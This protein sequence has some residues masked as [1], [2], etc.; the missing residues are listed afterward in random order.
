MRVS[1]VGWVGSRQCSPPGPA[2]RRV[3]VLAASLAL[4][5]LPAPGA[6]PAAAQGYPGCR[7]EVAAVRGMAQTISNCSDVPTEAIATLLSRTDAAY[8]GLIRPGDR[9]LANDQWVAW[10][11]TTDAPGILRGL[12]AVDADGRFQGMTE[13]TIA[14]DAAKSVLAIGKGVFS[15]SAPVGYKGLHVE[16]WKTVQ[17]TS[18]V[19]DECA[20]AN[21]FYSVPNGTPYAN[22]PTTLVV[23]GSYSVANYHSVLV[24]GLE[25]ARPSCPTCGT[26]TF[27]G[28]NGVAT[29]LD[30]LVSYVVSRYGFTVETALTASADVNFTGAAGGL[31]LLLN[32]ACQEVPRNAYAND[33]H[34]AACDPAAVADRSIH[35]FQ[36]ASVGAGRAT[37]APGVALSGDVA[38]A[39]PPGSTTIGP[40]EDRV[41]AQ[42]DD[43]SPLSLRYGDG[44]VAMTV[45]PGW[46]VTDPARQPF[47]AGL[48]SHFNATPRALGWDGGRGLTGLTGVGSVD[49]FTEPPQGAAC[50]ASP[51][52]LAV[53]PTRGMLLWRVGLDR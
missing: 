1:K 38:D 52:S 19:G 31:L 39:F 22:D 27:V 29:E 5:V 18:Q 34:F 53:G 41:V 26:T 35:Q 12:W 36:G 40:D 24:N 44:R 21:C 51:C 11:D 7:D 13:P 4:L 25:A 6:G 16:I 30:W 3:A 42:T 47:V 9:L 8:L 32:P 20:P 46:D 14:P 45:T 2:A 43:R 48:A 17:D 33:T 28:L 49:A 23:T 50:P 37:V 15:T 10:V